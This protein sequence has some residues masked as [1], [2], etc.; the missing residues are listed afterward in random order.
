MTIRQFL[1]PRNLVLLAIATGALLLLNHG[2]SPT[3]TAAPSGVDETP[4]NVLPVET[5]TTTIS[6]SYARQRVY[7]G[8]VAARR[9]A[10]LGFERLGKVVRILVDDGAYVEAH[11]PLAELDRRELTIRRRETRALRDQAA[12]RLAELRAGPRTQVIDAARAQV[13]DLAAQL[14]LA[15]RK[16]RRA[17]NL[18]A[19]GTIGEEAAEEARFASE[20]LAARLAAA[21]ERLAELVAGTRKERLVAQAALV[22]QLDARLAA[23]DLDLEKSVLKAPFAGRIGARMADEGR[24]V[25]AREPVLRLVESSALE[26]RVG[27]PVRVAA[28]LAPG[29]VRAV[30]IDGR[31]HAATVRSLLPGV[32]PASRTRTVVLDLPAASAATA[33][34]GQIVRLEILET[35]PARGIWLPN[36]AL[37]K[38]TRGLWSVYV[39]RDARIE[40]RRVELIFTQSDR[41]LVRGTLESGER[42]VVAGAH[43][44]V[45]GQ[46]VED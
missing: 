13:R 22:E 9:T 2:V 11:A 15:E 41:V 25:A 27:V 23:I 20:A 35:V 46:R 42:V 3:A 31:S 4:Q 32:D 17:R 16:Q 8:T 12:A 10:D 30:R 19:R 14:E 33:V 40:S 26:A 6:D 36:T 38:G 28:A 29:A 34:P 7:T 39:V 43:R 21:R 18:H 24:V 5:L 1:T 45:P 44:V 37:R